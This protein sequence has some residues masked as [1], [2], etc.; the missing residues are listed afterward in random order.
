MR[1]KESRNINTSLHFL[2]QVIEKLSRTKRNR[3]DHIEFR[4]S[5]LTKLLKSSLCGKAKT[6]VICTVNSE[7]G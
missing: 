2:C 5:K 7:I 6:S 1:L 4:N 3:K